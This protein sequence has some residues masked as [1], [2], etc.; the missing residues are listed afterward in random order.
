MGFRIEDGKGTGK[1][2]AVSARN[3]LNVS[4]VTTPIVSDASFDGDAYSLVGSHTLQASDTDENVFFLKN[5]NADK[6]VYLQSLRFAT[7]TV[8]VIGKSVFG[9]TRTSG[10]SAKTAVQLNRSSAKSSSVTAYDNST[11]NLVLDVTQALEFARFRVGTTMT[12]FAQS[13]G[14]IIL[15]PG[16]TWAI[17]A[18]G[19]AGDIIDISTFFFEFDSLV[20]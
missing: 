11:N 6:L 7:E 13:D 9:T 8:G 17:R 10:G 15:G 19:T 20:R 3:R 5:D 2:A 16:D 12:F 14:A 18:Q 1:F 4:A